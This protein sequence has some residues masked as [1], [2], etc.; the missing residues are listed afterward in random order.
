MTTL[1]NIWFN[2]YRSFR[3]WLTELKANRGYGRYMVL[4]QLVTSDDEKVSSMYV[5]FFDIYDDAIH[6][7]NYLSLEYSRVL[8]NTDGISDVY[9]NTEEDDDTLVYFI[10]TDSPLMI[11]ISV[12]KVDEAEVD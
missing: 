5:S 11:A 6:E 7:M 4:S 3:N 10:V 8:K 1:I 2:L 12:N 9:V